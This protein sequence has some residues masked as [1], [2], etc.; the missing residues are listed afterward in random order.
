M[1]PILANLFMEE[2]EIK[3]SAQLSIPQEFGRDM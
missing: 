3:P 1:S 2:F